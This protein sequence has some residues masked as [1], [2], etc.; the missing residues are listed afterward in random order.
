[1]I[2]TNGDGK[3][4]GVSKSSQHSAKR[5]GGLCDLFTVRLDFLQQQE[6]QLR[7]DVN[8]QNFAMGTI[9]PQATANR[10]SGWLFCFSGG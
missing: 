6:R 9:D 1:M 4:A 7:H 3:R 5:C 2:A 8:T 10:I